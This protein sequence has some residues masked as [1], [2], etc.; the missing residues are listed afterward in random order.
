MNRRRR[1][2]QLPDPQQ[3]PADP[4]SRA[5]VACDYV[6]A[7]GFGSAVALQVPHNG[8][9][10]VVCASSGGA[11][12][13]VDIGRGLARRVAT[14][15]RPVELLDTSERMGLRKWRHAGIHLGHVRGGS[16]VLIV[17]D[18]SLTRREGQA[19]AAWAAP[20]MADGAHVRGGPCVDLARGLS[21]EFGADAV[22][23]ALFAQSG[24]HL[25][26]HLR[27]GGLLRAWRV[28]GDTVWGEVARHGAAFTL[29]D[30]PMH[31]GVELLASLGMRT[32]GLVGLENGN[33]LAIGALGVA[34][35]GNLDLDV[36][37]HLLAR[38]PD[39]GRE[40]MTRLS[41]TPVPVPDEDGT[42]DLQALS[43]RV[44]CRRFA[45][46]EIRGDK[47]RLVAAHARDG[48]RL[49]SAPDANEE[50]LVCW[51]VDKGVGVVN[52]DAA[53]VLIGDHT[54]LYAQD[55]SKRALERL[56]LALQDVRR[57]PFGGVAA[58]D[59]EEADRDADLD[60]A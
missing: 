11:E 51:A 42:V 20:D 34:S 53:A 37:H 47:L 56:R 23:F 10:G 41:E 58:A 19:L 40:I 14:S 35:F 43:R 36:A 5:R 45:M 39:L 31:P 46:Y 55:P 8:G 50:E 13:L 18:T 6:R 48:S 38:S 1:T 21:R 22:V 28:P 30:L 2:D 12:A 49:A 52:E 4:I 59:E 32:A 25:S 15:G 44:G 33:G 17:S 26:L 9:Q 54:V 24:M 3:L 60:A 7:L 57:N 16:I 29:G 27:S